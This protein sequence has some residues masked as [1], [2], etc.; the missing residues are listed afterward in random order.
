MSL[1][2]GQPGS[3]PATLVEIFEATCSKY[4]NAVAISTESESL[5][6]RKLRRRAQRIA[7][8]LKKLGVGPGDRV[9][10]QLETGTCSLYENILG[11]LWSGAAYVPIDFEDSA[12]RAEYVAEQAAVVATINAEGIALHKSGSGALSSVTPADD[13]WVMF[14]SGSTG[15]PKGVAIQHSAAANLVLAEK[16]LFLKERPLTVHDNVAASLSPSFDASV[17]EIWLAWASGATLVPISRQVLTSGPDLAAHLSALEITAFSTLPSIARFLVGHEF[18]HLRLLILGGEALGEALAVSLARENLEVWNTYGPTETT[19]IATAALLSLQ[20]PGTIGTPLAGVAVA[21]VNDDGAL[22]SLGETGELVISGAGLGRYID[23]NLDKEKF[24]SLPRL[25]WNRAYFTGDYVQ[26]TPYGLVFAGRVDDQVKIAGKRIDLNE[27]QEAALAVTGVTGAAALSRKSDEEEARVALVLTLSPN[28]RVEEVR[29]AVLDSLPAGI[30]PLFSVVDDLPRLPSGKVD[31]SAI[32]WPAEADIGEPSEDMTAIARRFAKVLRL[33]YVSGTADFFAEGGTSIKAAQL[34]VEL[35]ESY[36]SVT[37]ADIYKSPTPEALQKSLEGRQSQPNNS[38]NT[39][40]PS[41]VFGGLQVLVSCLVTA[42]SGMF[43]VAITGAF[44]RMIAS[45][46]QGSSFW[47]FF[48]LF[49][50]IFPGLVRTL[51]AGGLVRA[52]TL[53]VRAGLYRRAGIVHFRLWLAERI[54]ALFQVAELTGTPWIKLFARITGSTLEPGVS[55]ETLP[56]VWGGLEVGRGTSIERDV[57]ISGWAC[58]ADQIVVGANS[59]GEN[60]R[61]GHRTCLQ[62]GTKVTSNVEI[63]SGALVDSDVANSGFYEGSPLR[64][65]QTKF[66]P[67]VEAPVSGFWKKLRLLVPSLLQIMS[68][69]Q[70]APLVLVFVFFG[71]KVTDVAQI[72][73]WFVQNGVFFAPMVLVTNALLTGL[74]IRIVSRRVREGHYGEDSAEGFCSWFVEKLIQRSREDSFWIYASSITPLWIRLLGGRVG[75]NCEISTLNGQVSLL[76]LGDECFLADDASVSPRESKNGWVFLGRS[77]L[78]RRVFVGN[79]ATLPA[80][81]NV[82]DEVLLAV[83]S[84]AP[85]MPVAGASYI[86]LPPIEFP[87]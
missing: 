42:I 19:V 41:R 64:H 70:Y 5:T 80:K 72:A 50:L 81:S 68:L 26:S 13:A 86:G 76:E 65:G 7:A 67:R 45:Y 11:V 28:A 35:R 62:P 44:L 17:E 36:P 24:A 40:R 78:G 27:I 69:V 39:L 46:D 66:W 51:L 55:L 14:T 83:A 18:D 37:V 71:P 75:R 16:A 85:R 57:H 23:V 87:R 73:F 20:T 43:F 9:L 47:L 21:V 77:S 79:S 30:S 10:I 33:R 3:S 15:K 31:R 48:P 60:V 82:P 61:I 29:R 25:G 54:V 84:A 38:N 52:V 4:P 53:G 32:R 59:I 58:E 12:A 2:Q 6:Y 49:V 8:R 34:A 56:P 74:L 63:E 22:V 1:Y